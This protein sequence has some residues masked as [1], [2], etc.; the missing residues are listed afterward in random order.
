M[1]HRPIKEIDAEFLAEEKYLDNIRQIV[2]ESCTTAGM[3]RKDVSAVLLAIE[4]GATNIIRHAYLYEKGTLRLRIVIYKKMIAFSLIDSGRSFQPDGSGKIDLERLVESGRKGGLGFYMIQRIMNSVEYISAAGF[5]ELRMIKR[6]HGAPGDSPSILRRMFT[7]RVKFSFWTMFIVCLIIGGTFYY[8]NDRTKKEV[9]AHLDDT[10]KALTASMAEQ[11]AGYIINSRSDVEFD[12]LIQSYLRSN[13]ILQL[14]VL[15]DSSGI[16][17]AHSE[18][19]L[20]LRKPYIPPNYIDVQMLNV[21]QRFI[22]DGSQKNYLVVPIKVG[23]RMLGRAF[24]IYSSAPIYKKLNDARMRFLALTGILLLVGVLGIYILSNYFVKPIVRITHRVRQFTSGDLE[25]ELPLEGADEFFE[26]SR[27]LN[28]M[29]TRLSRDRKNVVAREKMAKEIE[30]ASQIQK[31][32]LPRKLPHL[33]GL[34]VDTFYRAASMVGGDLYDIFEIS[35]NRYCLVVADVSGK[36]VPASLVMSM[37][38]TVIRIK[39][40]EAV[41][42]K[43]TLILVNDY[44][45][46]NIP[47]GMFITVL[48]AIYDASDRKL[49]FVSAGHN[50]MLLYRYRTGKISQINPTGMPLG[51]PV[52]LVQTFEESLEEVSLELEEGDVFFVYTDGITEATDREGNQY[53]MEPLGKFM[54]GQLSHQYPQ[55]ISDLSRAIVEEIDNYAGFMKQTDDITFILARSV[56]SGTE[57]DTETAREISQTIDTQN[58]ENSSVKKSDE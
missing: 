14:I 20:N 18:D 31:T 45:E 56:L 13:P 41:S 37:I 17:L 46:K 12:E 36:G 19:I 33:P 50:P 30:V 53:G 24:I 28:D 52:T 27:A 11:V 32:L 8:I 7:L 51:F 49:N 34:E 23:E 1:F 55:K 58:I 43:E 25:T 6:I 29:M 4:E 26:I 57:K 40:E 54:H 9:Y 3:S 48:L 21:T 35:S 15:T 16:I 22:V 47:P 39:S 2:K 42:A 10:V 5:N 44:M 38:R